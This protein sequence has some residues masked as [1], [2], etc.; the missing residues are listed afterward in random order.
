[1]LSSRWGHAVVAFSQLRALKVKGHAGSIGNELADGLAR[2]G[3]EGLAT[4]KG[5]L[6]SATLTAEVGLLLALDSTAYSAPLLGKN[7]KSRRAA[8]PVAAKVA[9]GAQTAPTSVRKLTADQVKSMTLG[10]TFFLTPK[11]EAQIAARAAELLRKA[12][13]LSE[14]KPAQRTKRDQAIRHA[15][16]YATSSRR[17]LLERKRREAAASLDASRS[18]LP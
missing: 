16:S 13:A 5:S 6:T 3:R 4:R 11:E 8:P 7:G 14:K 10:L 17:S 12:E 1:M 9:P 15:N 2:E 18:A